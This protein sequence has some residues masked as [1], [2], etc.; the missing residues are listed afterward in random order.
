MSE[1]ALTTTTQTQTALERTGAGL[2]AA[3]D[4]WLALEV[5]TGELAQTTADTY[6]RGM[7]KFVEWGQAQPGAATDH[8]VKE[9]L[10]SL[11]AAGHSQNAVA[12]WFAGVRS[13]F[14][15]AVSEH[16]VAVDPTAGIKRGRRKKANQRHKRE[17]LTDAEML[18]VLSS[19]LSARDRA[20]VHLLA[21]TG[22]RGIEL[23]RADI[24]HL[25]TEGGELV[26]L[27]QGKGESEANSSIVIAHPDA[28]DA[29]YNYL[30]ERGT[31]KGPLFTSESNRTKGGR[32]SSRALR[33]TVRGILDNAGITTRAKST[34][35]FRHTAITAAIRGGASLHDAQAMAR[36]T[37]PNTTM[38]YFH[39]LKRMEDAAER[40]ISYGSN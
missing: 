22:A 25:R 7:R 20:L 11:K 17:M 4:R 34:H 6:R 24:E 32:L 13:F 19:K 23:Q 3:W 40:R 28:R 12:V 9:W 21:Y 36:H 35:S 18:R 27:V 1:T 30:A 8:A 33:E 29:I 31:D 10:A 39:N 26:L 16:H 5:S 14:Q 38:V 2:V 15:W 37:N